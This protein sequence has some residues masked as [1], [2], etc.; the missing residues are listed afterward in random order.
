MTH[1]AKLPHER[2]LRRLQ[3]LKNRLTMDFSN[4]GQKCLETKRLR[5][6]DDYN[7]GWN[8]NG[9]QTRVQN[10]TMVDP[11]LRE[12]YILYYHAVNKITKR[13]NISI[14][15]NIERRGNLKYDKGAYHIDHMVS[16]YDGFILN[17][18]PSILGHISNLEC[19]PAVQN[20]KKGNRS[21]L[22]ETQLYER[23]ESWID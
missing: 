4:S 11:D 3:L 16:I 17:I 1:I 22:T 13:Q 18:P 9:I 12:E 20:I 10:G 7:S 23:Y 19:I 8:V 5:Y 15:P 21:S 14:L 2:V 6:G